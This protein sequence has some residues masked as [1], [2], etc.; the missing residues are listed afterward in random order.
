MRPLAV[1][2]DPHFRELIEV[3]DPNYSVP[4][5]NTVRSWSMKLCTETAAKVKELLYNLWPSHPALT[6]DMW[7]A[8]NGDQFACVSVHAIDE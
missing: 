7:S 1:V 2:D 6:A 8:M 3:F 5:R 4:S